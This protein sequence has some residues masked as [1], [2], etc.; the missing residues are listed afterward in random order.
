MP[1]Y[2]ALIAQADA[3]RKK[4]EV[5]RQK[6]LHTVVAE[7]QKKMSEWGISIEDLSAKPTRAGKVKPASGSKRVSA[8]KG[9]KVPPKYRHE[10]NEWTGRGVVPNWL[11]ELEAAGRQRDEFLIKPAA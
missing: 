8:A 7:I 9:K 2:E 11:K 4:A 3:L 1:S 6:K 5:Q 10:A